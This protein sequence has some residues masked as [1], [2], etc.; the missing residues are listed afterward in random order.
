MS[1]LPQDVRSKVLRHGKHSDVHGSESSK[2]EMALMVFESLK[3][4]EG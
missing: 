4:K 2:R 3:E 1:S